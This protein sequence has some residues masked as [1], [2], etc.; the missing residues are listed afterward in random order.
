[1]KRIPALGTTALLLAMIACGG[2]AGEEPAAAAGEAEAPAAAPAAEAAP[3]S[4]DWLTLDE[5]AMTATLDIVAGSTTDNNSWNFNG[6]VNGGA[7][8][9]VP[10]GYTVTI[11]FSNEDPNMAHSIGVDARTGNFPPNIADPTPVFAGAMSENPTSL[12]DATM[13]GEAETITFTADAAGEYSLVCYVPGHAVTG[14]W[15]RFNVS[16]DGSSGVSTM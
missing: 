5:G 12:V 1:M 7:T 15:I 2:D 4:T 14:M 8:V 11:N 9:T 13:P 16:D 3:V 6:F 10:V